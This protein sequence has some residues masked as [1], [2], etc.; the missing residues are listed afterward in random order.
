M[1][2]RRVLFF[3]FLLVAVGA[4]AAWIAATHDDNYPLQALFFHKRF[5]RYD[6]MIA[7]AARRN[8]VPPELVKAVI[9]RESRFHP[10]KTGTSG[11][12]GLMQITEPAAREWARAEKVETFA[13]T[14]LFD[15]KTNIDAGTWYLAR[16]LRHWSGRDDPIPFALAEYNAGRSRVKR[17]ARSAHEQGGTRAA[18]M[19]AAMDFPGTRQYV[20]DIMARYRAFVAGGEFRE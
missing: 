20:D 14:D 15:P 6:A 19:G 4:A 13:P 16:A 10:H 12:R 2:R 18:D 3:S 7:D 1:S 5:H 11:E 8:G 9:W 17:W